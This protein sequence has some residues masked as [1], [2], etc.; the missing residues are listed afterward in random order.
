MKIKIILALILFAAFTNHDLHAQVNSKFKYLNPLPQG[1]TLRWCQMWDANTWYIAGDFGTFMRTTNA[2]VNWYINDRAG[3][4]ESEYTRPVIRDAHFFNMNTGICVGQGGMARTTNGGVSFDS[5]PGAYMQSWNAVHFIN[6]NTG[7]AVGNYMQ[8]GKFAMTT[9][10]GLTWALNPNFVFNNLILDVYAY[11]DATLFVALSTGNI[12]RSSN[13]GLNWSVI[14]TGQ[15]DYITKIGF[16]N[17][18]TGFACGYSGQ[19]IRTVNGGL[20]WTNANTGLPVTNFRDIDFKGTEIYL[21]GN[22]SN[23]YKS[24]NLGASWDAIQ[25]TAPG[26]AFTGTF[27]SFD[28]KGDTLLAAGDAGLINK[29]IGSSNPVPLNSY[30]KIGN[31]PINDICGYSSGKV[32][33]VGRSQNP[34]VTFDQVSYSSNSGATWISQPVLNSTAEFKTLCMINANTGYIA[35]TNGRARKTTNGGTTWDSLIISPPATGHFY[36]AEF[37]DANTGWL[38]GGTESVSSIIYKTTDGGA[39]WV[40]QTAP[41]L[42]AALACEMIDANT[43]WLGGYQGYFFK[44]TNGGA[45][46]ESQS[47]QISSETH[48][49]SDIQMTGSGTIYVAGESLFRKSTNNGADWDTVFLPSVND[50]VQDIDFLDPLNGIVNTFHCIF[51]TSNG[52]ASWII[53]NVPTPIRKVCMVNMDTVFAAGDYAS[54]L[55][56]TNLLVGV[57]QEWINAVPEKYDLQQNYPNPFNPA[58]TIQFSMPRPGSVTLKVFDISGKEVSSLYEN[59]YFNRGIIKYNFDASRLASGVYFYSLTVDNEFVGTRKMVL[60]K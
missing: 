22:A 39:T 23:V 13:S 53:E 17:N 40:T 54:V 38:V 31:I 19:V 15:L 8:A 43:G 10:G 2:G 1:N 57:K 46:W 4:L 6:S 3:R 5:I 58:T 21:T 60:V 56:C 42:N 16:I 14:N 34:G 28:L 44:T 32:W 59:M 36:K 37:I 11:N 7:Y 45:N 52:G 9:D 49:I 47:K 25:I 51:R 18:D 26:Q 29:K 41:F 48:P 12:L 27:F 33:A 55:R 20:N 35:G 30:F 24:T 50:W